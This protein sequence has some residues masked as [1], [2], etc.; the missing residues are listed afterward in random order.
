[1]KRIGIL[2]CLIALA[3]TP[4]AARSNAADDPANQVTPERTFTRQEREHWAFQPVRRSAVPGV[5]N[6]AWVRTPIDAFVLEKL[7][8]L[9]LSPAPPAD[10]RTLLRRVYLD[11]I[12]LPPTPE[13]QRAFMADD[14]PEAFEKV[15]D[16]LLARPQYG[17]RWA[18]HWLDVARYAESNGYERDGAKPHVWRYRDYVINSLNADKPYDRFLI[19]QLAG[20]EIEGS[21]AE[22]Q[23][24]TTFLRLGTWDDEPADPLPDRYDQLD[25]VLGTTA[26]AFLGLT[27]RCARCHD[28]KFE[29]FSQNDYHRILAIFEPLKRPEIIVSATHRKEHDIHVGT[30]SE[31]AVYREATAKAD[32]EVAVLQKQIDDLKMQIRDRLFAEPA[33]AKPPLPRG[34]GRGEG[35]APEIVSRGHGEVKLPETN[36]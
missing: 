13:E 35:K 36:S 4:D 20:D 8:Q 27:L 9:G 6:A 1:M 14:S 21:N 3:A 23:I 2:G 33:P 12:G 29:P 16:G 28:H 22:T 25:D 17:E 18:R 26:T 15:V 24:A 19:E 31:L 10:R 11:L 7:E 32:A 34:E 30:E 5:R